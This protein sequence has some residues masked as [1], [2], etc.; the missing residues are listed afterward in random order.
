M[1]STCVACAVLALLCSAGS[2]DAQKRLFSTAFG[3]SFPAGETADF[4]PD[5]SWASFTIEARQLVDPRLSVGIA[6]SFTELSDEVDEIL[7]FRQLEFPDF[8]NV[9]GNLSGNQFRTI[10]SMPLLLTA[11]Y[12]P[13][14]QPHKFA[15][16]IGAGAGITFSERRLNIGLAEFEDDAWALTL[17]PQVG[18]LWWTSE[19][20]AFGVDGRLTYSLGDD[21]DVAYW[22]INLGVAWRL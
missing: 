19:W 21:F 12:H 17:A 18:L 15:P 20:V 5:A 8:E 9:S 13:I 4:T 14:P 16:Y 6:W 1:R 2:A 11:F 22:G 7:D 10:N 3:V